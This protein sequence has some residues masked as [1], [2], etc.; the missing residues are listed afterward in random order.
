MGFDLVDAC[1]ALLEGLRS[2]AFGEQVHATPVSG[3]PVFSSFHSAHSAVAL[4]HIDPAAA[5]AELT[6]L[7]RLCQLESGLVARECKVSSPGAGGAPKLERS[8]FIAPPVSAYAVAR[9]AL[10]GQ[11]SG[12]DLLE[13]ATREVDAIWGERLPPDTGLPVILHPVESGVPHSALFEGVVESPPG[14]EWTAEVANLARSALSCQLDPGYALR[15]GHPFV[16]EDPVFCGWLLLALEE[17]TRA[18]EERG[19]APAALKLRVRSSMIRDALEERLW[20]ASEEIYTA[21]D[22]ARGEPLRGVTLGGLVPAASRSLL[23]EGSAKRAVDRHLRPGGS[24]LW[25]AQGLSLNP[26]RTGRERSETRVGGGISPLAHYWGHL[27]LVRAGRVSDAR[28][29]RT[30]LETLVE[31]HGF[32]GLYDAVSGVGRQQDD[33]SLGAILLEM[34]AVSDA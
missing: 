17:L 15:A 23:D 25:G 31:T 16:V 12:P 6:A 33:A 27:A 11:L 19:A 29:A 30:Q 4:R 21:L 24:S 8:P 7:Y 9:L 34:R 14:P 2:D 1:R 10:D 20:W 28:V 3:E 13:R 32:F 5:C 26:V 18:W 22:R